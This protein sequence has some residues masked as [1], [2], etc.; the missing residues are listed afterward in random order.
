MWNSST[1]IISGNGLFFWTEL[2]VSV[3]SQ[4]YGQPLCSSFTSMLSPRDL[5]GG[6]PHF[7][8]L[9]LL[10]MCSILDLG[11]SI[12]GGRLG[13]C[14]PIPINKNLM[15]SGLEFRDPGTLYSSI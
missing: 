6:M 13:S 3:S 4:L 10:P 11:F 7:V 8:L 2:Y 5:W 1:T 15:A 9:C 14:R 12:S